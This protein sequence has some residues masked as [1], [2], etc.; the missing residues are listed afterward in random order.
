MRQETSAQQ[1]RHIRIHRAHTH[2][3]THI[4][5]HTQRNNTRRNSTQLTLAMAG[6][7]TTFIAAAVIC[8]GVWPNS[9]GPNNVANEFRDFEVISS[10]QTRASSAANGKAMSR[11]CAI[12]DAISPTSASYSL[13]RLW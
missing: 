5:T 3:H 1:F 7:D 13:T 4:R 8:S 6:G 10:N 2:T 11:E 9:V 12:C